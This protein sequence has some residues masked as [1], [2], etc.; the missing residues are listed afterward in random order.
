MFVT[1]LTTDQ[2]H[3]HKE[4]R[5]FSEEASALRMNWCSKQEIFKV[6]NPATKQSRDFVYRRTLYMGASEDLDIG[7]WEYKSNDGLV[8]TI[9]ND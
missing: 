1:E 5:S 4:S 9:W 7:G 2:L 8:L 6:T 3:Y